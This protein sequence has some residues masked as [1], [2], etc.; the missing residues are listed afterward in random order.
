MLW[1]CF[2]FQTHLLLYS[3]FQFYKTTWRFSSIPCHFWIQTTKSHPKYLEAKMERDTC[4]KG[5]NSSQTLMWVRSI[6]QAVGSEILN[7]N[8]SIKLLSNAWCLIYVSQVCTSLCRFLTWCLYSAHLVHAH[9]PDASQLRSVSP[10]NY[11][12]PC[13]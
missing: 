5:M 3:T 13:H 2:S 1:P 4:D 6:T 7:Y 9:D 10:I 12:V 11:S 8:I